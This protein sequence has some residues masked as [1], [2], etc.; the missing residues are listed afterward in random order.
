MASVV[1]LRPH[2]REEFTASVGM[3]VFLGSWAMMFAALFF[4]Y[5]FIRARSLVWPPVG[6]PHLPV[7]LPLVNTA[8]LLSSSFTFA[9]ALAVLRR[10]RTNTF[11]R[12]VAATLLLGTVFLV[13]QFVVWRSVGLSGLHMTTGLYGS[14]FYGLTTFHALHFAVGLAILVWVLIRSLRGAY[15]VHSTIGIRLCTMY[16]HFVDVVWVLM[17]VTVYL[18]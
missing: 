4:A 8:V 10:G 14:V 1:E 17:F 13:L 16:W 15:S 2:A 5:G 3:F 11:T 7:A 6:V 18:L 9:R 12:W